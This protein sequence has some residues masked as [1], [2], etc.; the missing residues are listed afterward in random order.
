[1]CHQTLL[2]WCAGASGLHELGLL[3]Q[4]AAAGGAPRAAGARW[5]QFWRRLD[6][7]GAWSALRSGAHLAALTRLTSLDIARASLAGLRL[8]CL[9]PT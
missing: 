4:K 1:M 6:L 2:C 9:R 5:R 3:K 7:P 8:W